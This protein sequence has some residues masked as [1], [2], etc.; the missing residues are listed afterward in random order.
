MDEVLRLQRQKKEDLR[1][2]RAQLAAEFS[3]SK[4]S[5]ADAMALL[6]LDAYKKPPVVAQEEIKTRK[7]QPE[8]VQH[9][10]SIIECICLYSDYY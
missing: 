7:W 8:T 1:K 6:P 10:R 9:V 5:S 2:G 3:T 4:W